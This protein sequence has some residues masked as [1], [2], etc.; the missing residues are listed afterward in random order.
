ML[1]YLVRTKLGVIQFADSVGHVLLANKLHHSGA[2]TVH[3]S[4]AYITCL[5][6]VIL[7]ILPASALRKT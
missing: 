3:I 6:H 7:Q 2:I 4:V 1:S 5:A